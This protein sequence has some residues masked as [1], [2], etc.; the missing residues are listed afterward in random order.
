MPSRRE[1]ILEAVVLALDSNGP[2]ELPNG[3][4]VEKPDDVTVD[5]RR[6][7]PLKAATDLPRISV[8]ARDEEVT[9]VTPSRTVQ[10]SDRK[11]RVAVVART[12]GTEETLDP[13]CQW[14]NAALLAPPTASWFL[15]GLAI[16]IDEDAVNWEMDEDTEGDF[17][18]AQITFVIRYVT[19]KYDLTA[20]S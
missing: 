14:I 9:R 2:I 18:V 12:N 6:R 11:M 17:S 20:Q 10:M 16:A 1:L 8:Y 15:T 5:R 4:T 19:S 13:L 3:T 7:Q